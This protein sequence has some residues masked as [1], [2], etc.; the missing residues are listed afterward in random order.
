M[1]KFLSSTFQGVGALQ[2]PKVSIIHNLGCVLAFFSLFIIN[3][4]QEAARLPA[5]TWTIDG[6][7]PLPL[8]N[9]EFSQRFNGFGPLRFPGN[10]ALTQQF[11][12][13]IWSGLETFS[14]PAVDDWAGQNRG[15]AGEVEGA[16]EAYSLS[17]S[18]IHR[19][20][21]K[22]FPEPEGRVRTRHFNSQI[23]M[24]LKVI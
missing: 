6:A 11:Q 21:K 3:N 23:A 13:L 19:R 9:P 15:I 4:L 22:E 18:D 20:R 14:C 2:L 24:K 1:S 8:K 17:E 7:I 12:F 5:E 16:K 10:T